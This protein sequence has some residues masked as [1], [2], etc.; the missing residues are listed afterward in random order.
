MIEREKLLKFIFIAIRTS[1]LI[2]AGFII[3]ELFKEFYKGLDPR[4]PEIT[5]THF[6]SYK[7]FNLF[8]IFV[9]DLVLLVL[10]YKLFG[11][12]L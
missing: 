8:M 10:I 12:E 1:L 2:G 4:I 7:V 5:I 3:Y 6:I 11:I 9:L